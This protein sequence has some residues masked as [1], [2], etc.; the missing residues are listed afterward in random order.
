M[1]A[2]EDICVVVTRPAHQAGRL[3]ALIAAEGGQA[4][5][6]PALAIGPPADHDALEAII[7]RIDTFDLAI[8]IS[9]N[10]VQWGLSAL[11]SRRLAAHTRLA[12]VGEATAAA[13]GEHGFGDVVTPFGGYNSEALLATEALRD[14]RGRRIVI[15][16]GEGGRELLG[17]TL[18]GRGADVVYAE[19]YRRLRPD[20]DPADLLAALERGEVNAV[21]VTSVEAVDNLLAMLGERGRALLDTVVLVVGSE[22]VAETCRARGCRAPLIVADSAADA[23]LV[24]AI[25]RWRTT[26]P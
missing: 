6:F 23:D 13:L 18:A 3:A 21:T 14:V 17:R 5:V 10:A 7:N 2:L 11:G 19:C 4:I 12:A 16:R 15:F 25:R 24:D 22:R 26:R 20:T 1:G 8:F 9:P